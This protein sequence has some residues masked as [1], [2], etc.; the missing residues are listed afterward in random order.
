VLSLKEREFVNLARMSGM[1]SREIA[2]KEVLPNMLAYVTMVF[3]LL[4]GGAMLAESWL[5]VMGLGPNPTQNVTLGSMI[6]NCRQSSVGDWRVFWWWW[7]PP[8][9]I[10]AAFLS[11][12][13]VMHASMDEM[14]N[15][16]LRRM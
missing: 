3:V 9:A 13:F 15:P 12:V 16:R 1:R 7:V 5:S 2:I 6:W 14:F 11:A 8:G 4:M 10:L